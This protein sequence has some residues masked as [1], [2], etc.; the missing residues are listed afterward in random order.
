MWKEQEKLWKTNLTEF[1]Y[2]PVSQLHQAES[3]LKLR[4][5]LHDAVINAAPIIGKFINKINCIYSVL[6]DVWVTHT[7]L[8]QRMHIVYLVSWP[9]YL[10]NKLKIK[11]G[12]QI[13][14]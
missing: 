1:I 8:R 11:S 14:F 10:L 3:D 2:L 13:F 5:C 6:Q 7:L 4:S 12:V 9:F